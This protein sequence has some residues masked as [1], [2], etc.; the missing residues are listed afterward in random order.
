MEKNLLIF[1]KFKLKKIKKKNVYQ[2]YINESE[3]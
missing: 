3:V 1:Y 2:F